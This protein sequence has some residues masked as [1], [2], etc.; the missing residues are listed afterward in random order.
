MV[1][2]A[3][4]VHGGI[5]GRGIS[6]WILTAVLLGFYVDLYYF[7]HLTPVAK[8][9]W[10]GASKWWLY[11]LLYT[12]AIL[13][14]GGLY[15]AKNRRSRYQVVRTVVVMVVQ[16]LL[17]FLV[18]MWMQMF[19]SKSFYFSYLWPLKIEYF[20]PNT[21]LGFPGWIVAYSFVA[22]LV[23]VPLLGFFV[24]KRWYCSWV[25]GCGGLANTFGDPWR[26]LSSKT[27]WS[28]KL[29]Q[30]SIHGVLLLALVTTGLVMISWLVGD[31]SSGLK[32]ITG[33]LQRHYGFFIGGIW[34][35][36]IGVSLY[37]VLGTRVWC[38]FGCPMAA[39]LGLIQRPGRYQIT[40]QGELCIACGNCSKYCEM[41]I[42]VR[43]YAMQGEPVNRASC[44]GCGLC[45]HV[46]PRGVLRLEMV[47]KGKA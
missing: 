29:E 30:Y 13:V 19:A 10:S 16:L 37:P 18:P 46:C 6:A 24:G 33:E 8:L 7:N 15:I 23:A 1:A 44:V 17:A 43:S 22:S 45:Q 12:V 39:L 31:S 40:T 21:I 5:R 27:R 14:A 2:V 36:V 26:H 35:G 4:G 32:S 38:R 20:Y 34:S 47:K 28:W 42:D 3:Q 11:G 25:C 41:G 9:I